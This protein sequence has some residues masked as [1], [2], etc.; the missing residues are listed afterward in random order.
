MYN[1]KR[2]GIIS[3]IISAI[4]HVSSAGYNIIG[5]NIIN[6]KGHT[7]E[8]TEKFYSIDIAKNVK[9]YYKLIFYTVPVGCIFG[10][11]LMFQYRKELDENKESTTEPLTNTDN[12]SQSENA[13]KKDMEKI[14]KDKR[15][16]RLAF[17]ILLGSFVLF[18][19]INNFKTIGATA[20]KRI[21]A[22]LLKY[23]ALCMGIFLCLSA[24][25]WGTLIDKF[26][27]KNLV[28]VINCLGIICG[29][30][31]I[32]GLYYFHLLFCFIVCL[33]VSSVSGLMSI[34]NPHIMKIYG[35]KYSMIVGGVVALI[36]GSSNLIGSI[37]SF[38]ISTV[39]ENN[40][41]FAYGC[42]YVIGSVLSVIS[43]L[44]TFGESNEPFK[45][46]DT[47]SIEKLS[48]M[49]VQEG[50]VQASEVGKQ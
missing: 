7:L 47:E 11:L 49:Y 18:L 12:T 5:E 26:H 22:F 32:I 28:L 40:I 4:G 10:L 43:L 39:L 33:S 13:M 29:I 19:V 44:L 6:P 14:F 9:Q 34:V 35:I 38:V 27:F 1:P 21:D 16:W 3:A 41:N 20:P 37:F 2:K 30:G 31:L 23:T 24:P 25:I 45:F 15:V 46:V 36:S 8:T 48:E 50:S 42:I 17:I